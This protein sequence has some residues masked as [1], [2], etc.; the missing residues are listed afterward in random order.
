MD[1]VAFINGLSWQRMRACVRN[2]FCGY[3]SEEIT[4]R[5]AVIF[6]KYEWFE[7]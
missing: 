4:V 2:A 3:F 1:A 5:D 7:S 6:S